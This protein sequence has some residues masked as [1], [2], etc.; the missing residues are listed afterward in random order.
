MTPLEE[1]WALARRGDKP[2]VPEVLPLAKH[3]YELP[4]HG[5][6]G[7]LHIVL[8]DGNLENSHL[9]FCYGFASGRGCEFCTTLAPVLRRMSMTQRKKIY[10]NV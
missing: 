8:D 6:G 1:V 9:D 7:C 4:E 10:A 2:T 5:S 3:V